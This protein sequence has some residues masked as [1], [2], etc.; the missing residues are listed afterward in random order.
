MTD[1][2]AVNHAVAFDKEIEAEI[3]ALKERSVLVDE[4]RKLFLT[5]RAPLEVAAIR[6]DPLLLAKP[7]KL[8]ERELGK[9]LVGTPSRIP[10]REGLAV[11]RALGVISL[12]PDDKRYRITLIDD[13]S[14]RARRGIH[15]ELLANGGAALGRLT[16]ISPSKNILQLRTRPARA[17]LDRA[18][19]CAQANTERQRGEA[20]YYVTEALASL[21]TAAQLPRAADVIR[22]GLDVVEIS[23]RHAKSRS[24][25][26]NESF[27]LPEAINA[28][29]SNAEAVIDQLAVSGG[30]EIAE[31][32]SGPARKAFSSYVDGRFTD[33]DFYL[34]RRVPD[35]GAPA[36]SV[37][38]ALPSGT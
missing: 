27:F 33:L 26:S 9:Y 28:R 32:A 25:A 35:V 29:I 10:V 37:Y 13:E 11:L 4:L 36:P 18:R 20:V 23:T 34:G 22:S 5:D 15:C 19:E 17:Y 3:Q 14:E 7:G 2:P 8:S 30:P 16:E 38:S 24:S 12:P 1:Q 31:E 6:D 21:A